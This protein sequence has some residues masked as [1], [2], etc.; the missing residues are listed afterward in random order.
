MLEPPDLDPQSVLRQFE[1]RASHFEDNDYLLREVETR[2]LSRLDAVRLAPQCIVDLGCGLGAGVAALQKRYPQA[3]VTGLDHSP[4]MLAR[5]RERLAPPARGLFAGL[6]ASLGAGSSPRQHFIEADIAAP[7]LP[8]DSVD[9][10]WSNLSLHWLARPDEA[11][12]ALM[13]IARP[14]ALLMFSVFGVDTLRQLRAPREGKAGTLM[15]F[16]DMHDWGDALVNAGFAEPVMDMERIDL[17]F[18]RVPD[19][20]RDLHRLGGN[21]LRSRAPGLRG[22]GFRDALQA[23]LQ[24][25]QGDGAALSLSFEIVFG[26]AWVPARKRREDGLSPIEF[27]PARPRK[28][29][30]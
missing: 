2:M 5:A 10:L 12:A 24:A 7:P 13:R 4:A 29:K 17:S 19:L 16:C 21:A 23:R 14:G 3:E 28:G 26:H 1:R 9:L 11:L 8:R 22:R 18:G 15:G 6:L 30:S 27:L 25:T 20:L